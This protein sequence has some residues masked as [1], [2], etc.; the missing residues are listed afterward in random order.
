MD[1][2]K[3]KEK[4]FQRPKQ[5]RDVF[6]L[7]RKRKDLADGD[8]RGQRRAHI[9]LNLKDRRRLQRDETA[10]GAKGRP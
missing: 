9:R 6:E 5:K 4:L 7:R 1:E 8:P 10:K 2:G 3:K